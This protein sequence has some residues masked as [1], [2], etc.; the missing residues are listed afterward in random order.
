MCWAQMLGR[1]LRI[2]PDVPAVPFHGFLVGCAYPSLSLKQKPAPGTSVSET[3]VQVQQGF[4]VASDLGH[5]TVPVT[6]FSIRP[7]VAVEKRRRY[8]AGEI[9]KARAK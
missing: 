8:A 9:P 6:P 3:L 5:Q 4:E 2:S 7:V 1:R